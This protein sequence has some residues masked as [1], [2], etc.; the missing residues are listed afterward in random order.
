MRLKRH[1]ERAS[2]KSADPSGVL[3]AAFICSAAFFFISSANVFG[4]DIAADIDPELLVGWRTWLHLTIQWTHLVGFA[5]WFGLI[6][7]TLLLKIT[8]GLDRLLYGSW[9]LF[10][11][12]LATGS[13][14]MEYSAG[15]PEVPSLFLLPLLARIP[16]GETY[17][18]VLAVKVG[19]YTLSVLI[20]L[21]ATLLHVSRRIPEARLTRYFLI[22]QSSLAATIAL[23]TAILLFYHEVADLWPTAIHSLG[24]VVGPEGPRGQAIINPNL[25]P[26]NDFRLLASSAAWIDIGLR[27]IHLMGFGLWLGGSAAALVLGPTLPARFMSVHWTALGLQIVSGV[28]SMVRWTPFYIAPYLWNLHELSHVRFGKNYALFMSAKH[29]LVLVAVSLAMLVTFRLGKLRE[30]KPAARSAMNFLAVA[31]LLLGLTI[32]Y[33]MMIVLLLHE[34]VDHAL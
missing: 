32:A 6:V 30:D 2:E 5:L 16:Y 11:L 21:L 4:H 31:S 26:P 29:T 8:P 22:S 15:I 33:V 7:G 24:G 25:P 27:W 28:A 14:N 1:L 10:L 12:M 34:A 20:T 9:A 18:I 17:T 13:Y 23:I 3:L 19:L